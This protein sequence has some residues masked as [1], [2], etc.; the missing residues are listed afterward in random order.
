MVTPIQGLLLLLIS[1]LEADEYFQPGTY[2]DHRLEEIPYSDFINKEL[3]TFSTVENIWS[4]PSVTHG[5]KP[6]Q[7]KVIRRCFCQKLA[8]EVKA[9]APF[10]PR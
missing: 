3:I 8:K 6:G 9:C 7:R 5:L 4:I 1:F 2:L 10:G